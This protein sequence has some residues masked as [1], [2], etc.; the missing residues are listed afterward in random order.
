MCPPILMLGLSLAGGAVQAMGAIQA[1]NAQAA[2]YRRQADQE[3]LRAELLD[4]QAGIERTTGQ[5]QQRRQGEKFDQLIGKQNA[6][7]A[8]SGLAPEGSVID[9]QADS[10]REAA[11]DVAAM[12]YSTELKADNLEYESQMA[13]VNS[14]ANLRAAKTAK[15]AGMMNAFSAGLSSIGGA[16]GRATGQSGFTSLG[17][18]F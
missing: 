6:L 3:R 8:Q 11:L 5:Y 4:R 14:G 10:A 18:K 9:V 1:G 13:S 7:Y 17:L 15:Q 12:Q 2:A 16:F